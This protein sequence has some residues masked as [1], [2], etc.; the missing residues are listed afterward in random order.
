VL[1]DITYTNFAFSWN[2]KGL[3]YFLRITV[4]LSIVL[5]CS[6]KKNKLLH[7][8]LHLTYSSS[9]WSVYFGLSEVKHLNL[10][11]PLILVVGS[12]VFFSSLPPYSSRIHQSTSSSIPGPIKQVYSVTSPLRI[13]SS[14]GLFAQ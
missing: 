14:Y 10:K 12:L 6:K 13:V 9:V 4:P 2:L 5:A 11:S 8:L 3:E 7:F 1:L